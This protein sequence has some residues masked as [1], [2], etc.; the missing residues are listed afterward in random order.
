MRRLWA[1]S[2]PSNLASQAAPYKSFVTALPVCLKC[3]GSSIAVEEPFF[4]RMQCNFATR[5]E[6]VGAVELVRGELR[7]GS[8]VAVLGFHTM[9]YPP[10][11]AS[12]APVMYRA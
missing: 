10:S 5:A 4:C 12:T 7:A 6:V 2:S 8:I 3:A 11:T 9:P 1:E